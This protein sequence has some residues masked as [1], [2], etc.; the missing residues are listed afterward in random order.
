MPRPSRPLR[1]AP[2][3]TPLL[4]VVVT[5]VTS[6]GLVAPNALAAPA[7]APAADRQAGRV[8]GTWTG[9]F[10]V[11]GSNSQDSGVVLQIRRKH[12]T[13]RGTVTHKGFCA[14][15]LAF[16]GREG[17]WFRF[18][19]VLTTSLREGMVCT[20]EVEL[21]VRRK[22]GRLLGVWSNNGQ[23]ARGTLRRG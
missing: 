1:P 15:R 19:E 10:D 5:A 3:V 9:P 6:L 18:T 8:T 23:T 16:K 12:G 7:A 22:G 11:T 14:G 21:E 13:Y 17:R 2:P 4:T 20:P